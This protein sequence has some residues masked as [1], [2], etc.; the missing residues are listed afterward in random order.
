MAASLWEVELAFCTVHTV[1]F[2]ATWTVLPYSIVV[3]CWHGLTQ[4]AQRIFKARAKTKK[5]MEESSRAIAR[6]GYR[7]A[8]FAVIDAQSVGG[9]GGTNEGGPTGASS[10]DESGGGLRSTKQSSIEVSEK[11]EGVEGGKEGEEGEGGGGGG[12]GGGGSLEKQVCDYS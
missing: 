7:T 12:G 1:S 11:E 8:T 4:R 10:F 9:G 3:I 5:Q 2:R 6:H